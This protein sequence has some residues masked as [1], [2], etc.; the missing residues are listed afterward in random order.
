MSSLSRFSGTEIVLAVSGVWN[1]RTAPRARGARR[2]H[3][4]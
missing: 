3:R 2:L 1:A 4:L